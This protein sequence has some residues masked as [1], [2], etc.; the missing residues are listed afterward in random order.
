MHSPLTGC[1]SLKKPCFAT[2]FSHSFS[3]ACLNSSGK[4]YAYCV[5]IICA[6]YRFGCSA[7]FVLYGVAT[8]CRCI[9]PIFVVPPMEWKVHSPEG[10][11]DLRSA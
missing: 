8:G 9:E 5:P 11:S 1:F 4:S 6:L 2:A 10:L 3:M 7:P